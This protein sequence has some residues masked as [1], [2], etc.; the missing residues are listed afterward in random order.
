MASSFII[1]DEIVM[2]PHKKQRTEEWADTP[3]HGIV[4]DDT[5]ELF[6][7]LEIL[8]KRLKATFQVWGHKE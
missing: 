4:L 6:D 5:W 1:L 8:V 2:E 7:D 3:D